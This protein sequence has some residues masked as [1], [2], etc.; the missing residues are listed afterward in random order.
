MNLLLV[1]TVETAWEKIAACTRDWRLGVEQLDIDAAADR[2]LAQDISAEED[3]PGF[4]RST[5]DGY[6]VLSADTAAAGDS[7]PVLLKLTGIVEMGKPAHICIKHGECAYVPT[8]GMIPQGADAVVMVEYAENTGDNSIAVY[9]PAAPGKG[10]A[11]ADEDMRRG[12]T[13]L[14]KGTFLRAP[15]TGALAALGIRRVP[16]FCPLRLAL[17]STGNELAAPEEKPQPGTIRDINSTAL[18]TLARQRGYSVIAQQTIA[19]DLNLLEDVIRHA[20]D[21][22]DVVVVSGGS[23]RGEKDYTA[24]A[25][26]RIVNDANQGIFTQGLAVKP[27]KP[28]IFG[29]DRITNT[30]LCGLPGHPV[31]A[32]IVFELFLS[33]LYRSLSCQR[34][35]LSVPARIDR[36][37]AAAP[38]K[39]SCQPVTLR[40][41]GNS[42]GDDY[43]AEPVFGKSGMISSLTR[44]DGY[45][46][47]E[48]NREGLKQ[49][50]PVQVFLF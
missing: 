20:L 18:S 40:R 44:A 31:S 42:N 19:D 34:E 14:R 38:G 11:E 17:F 1:D 3:I 16:V 46:I 36:N 48:Q 5:V 41:H 26:S 49:G 45:I 10:I 2:I 22:A 8:G 25:F 27:G 37:L 23:S 7:I 30:L 21:A 12:E 39:I 33:R 15:E 47:I 6:A 9:E 4:R 50:E 43:I 28:T 32:I 35:P 29:Y 13:V 24:E